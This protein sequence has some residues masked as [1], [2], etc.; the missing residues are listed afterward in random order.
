M[1]ALGWGLALSAWFWLPALAET[2]L[3]QTEPI[4]SG[5]FHYANHFRGTDLVQPSLLFSYDVSG[6]GA[7]RMGLLQALLIVAGLAVLLLALARK[8]WLAASGVR[9]GAGSGF[10]SCW[11]C[12]WRRR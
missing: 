9:A 6:G 12:S 2:G 11:V 3:A 8:G 5:Y 1:L 4:T 7:F 10:F